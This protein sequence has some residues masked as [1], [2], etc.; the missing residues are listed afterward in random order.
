MKKII[1]IGAGGHATSIAETIISSGNEI[2][3]F[4]DKYKTKNKLLD[5]NV[6]YKIKSTDQPLN[7]VIAIGD[8]YKRQFI[9][10][11][12]TEKFPKVY[13]PSVV[14]KTASVSHFA[15]I[16]KGSVILQNS[17]VGANTI[18]GN[19]CIINTNA[20]IDHD[21]KL[22]NFLSLAPASVTGGKVKIGLRSAIG[23]NASI[24]HNINI[25]KDVIVGSN[26]YV[27]KDIKKNLLVY[28]SP[29]KIIRKRKIGASYL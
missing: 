23:I 29:A 11:E 28:G 16:G 24:K 20:S 13:F 2:L 6:H 22:N 19:F 18:I 27:D 15:K 7:I 26:S 21:C 10:K 1:V 5:Y 14:H 17:T 12:I 25:S 3:Y 8:N 9:Y 4:V